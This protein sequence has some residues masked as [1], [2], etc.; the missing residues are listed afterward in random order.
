MLYV[1]ERA[2]FE[3]GEGGPVLVEIAP[4][5]DLE[6]DVLG[7]MGFSPRVSPDLRRMDARLFAEGRMDLG[8][9]LAKRP[10]RPGPK[11]LAE[12]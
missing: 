12:G 9:D 4:G 7:A 6:R 5:A 1:T 3:L 10:S 8:A 11:R 2:V